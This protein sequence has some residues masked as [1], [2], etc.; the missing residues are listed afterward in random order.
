MDNLTL[1]N[2]EYAAIL[3]IEPYTDHKNI[4]N[5]LVRRM[6][7]DTVESKNKGLRSHAKYLFEMNFRMVCIHSEML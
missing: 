7:L 4:L 3:V 6:A 5:K 2:P 1:Q